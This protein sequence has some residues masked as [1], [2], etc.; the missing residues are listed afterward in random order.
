MTAEDK[1][2]TPIEQRSV[3]FCGDDLTA[4]R[5]DD[6]RIY[7]GLTQMRSAIGVDAQ[8]QRRRIERHAILGKGLTNCLPPAATRVVLCCG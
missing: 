7:A 5:A 4:V 6:G 2:L 8:G 1:A 3:D